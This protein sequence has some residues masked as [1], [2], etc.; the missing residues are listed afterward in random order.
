GVALACDLYTIA[1]TPTTAVNHQGADRRIVHTSPKNKAWRSATCGANHDAS[2][3]LDGRATG[4]VEVILVI[5]PRLHREGLA[6]AELAQ[7]CGNALARAHGQTGS[8]SYAGEE[9]HREC[10]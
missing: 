5:R 4:D 7:C 6:T 1:N 8:G 2:A 10:E 9:E 3:S